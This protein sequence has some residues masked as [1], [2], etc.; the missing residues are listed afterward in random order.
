MKDSLGRAL[1][2]LAAVSVVVFLAIALDLVPS[3]APDKPS[4]T[5]FD[6]AELVE[7]S[8]V[9]QGPAPSGAKEVVR[10]VVE[11]LSVWRVPL[12]EVPVEGS[13]R[14]YRADLENGVEAHF[15][16]CR[17]GY[18]RFDFALEQGVFRAQR[19]AR[20]PA[21]VELPGGVAVTDFDGDG[22]VDLLLGTS[23]PPLAIH[24]PGAGAFFV[25]GRKAGGY[26]SA[27][28]LIET[29]VSGVLALPAEGRPGSD[30]L[31]LTRGD[32]SAQRPGDLVWFTG[33]LAF[34]RAAQISVG[35]SPRDLILSTQPPRSVLLALPTAG[36]VLRVTLPQAG[37]AA[38]SASKQT[39][40]LKGVQGLLADATGSWVLARDAKDLKRVV[41]DDELSAEAWAEGANV[42]PGVV[43]D[44][45][46]DSQLEVLARVEGG[47]ARVQK[48]V[49]PEALEELGLP[50]EVLDVSTLRDSAR[51][52]HPVALSVPPGSKE[53]VLLVLPPSPWQVDRPL[54]FQHVELSE[55]P[56]FAV[57]PLE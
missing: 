33:G 7:R 46:G 16:W 44:F 10:A 47:V 45:D 29:P 30:F 17:G 42:G 52:T 9:A 55:A 48:G 28:A 12:C 2:G 11:P 32:A 4:V 19:L 3:S 15:V 57:V 21:R 18:V 1:S 40:N 36:M 38:D 24:R 56:S 13:A 5:K 39:L 34:Q 51:R 25:R 22:V 6:P 26:E 31:V 49:D 27:R 41:F 50:G 8:N 14:I 53:L 23:P 43:L 37:A 35:L 20:F 54:A